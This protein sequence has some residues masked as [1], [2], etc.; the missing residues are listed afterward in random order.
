MMGDYTIYW[1]GKKDAQAVPKSFITAPGD[2][3]ASP[4]DLLRFAVN[5]VPATPQPVT[6]NSAPI[7]AG[8][9][10]TWSSGDRWQVDLMLPPRPPVTIT[11]PVTTQ[12]GL[13][14]QHAASEITIYEVW[15]STPPYFAPGDAGSERIGLLTPGDPDPLSSS[16]PQILLFMG[17]RSRSRP[18]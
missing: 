9:P 3:G 4:G 8:T 7:P 5:G 17:G 14:W 15:R 13:G 11:L 18:R 6:R 10:V 2:Q 16:P 12:L 1:H